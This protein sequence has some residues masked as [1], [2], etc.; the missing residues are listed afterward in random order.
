[1]SD[2]NQLL[3]DAITL[4]SARAVDDH[5]KRVLKQKRM[6][7]VQ[8]RREIESLKDEIVN[9]NQETMERQG[10]VLQR[11]VG[12]IEEFRAMVS[13]TLTSTGPIEEVVAAHREINE[14]FSEMVGTVLT[15]LSEIS[16]KAIS[17][18][19]RKSRQ[20]PQPINVSVPSSAIQVEP[21]VIVQE[22]P[23]NVPNRAIVKHSDGTQSTIEFKV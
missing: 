23:K 20:T 5:L 22:A 8:E 4:R 15:K 1:M 13:K 10:E 11:M 18:A 6:A 19:G 7:V 9:S 16:E 12:M 14:R 2:D 21:R 3:T 17:N